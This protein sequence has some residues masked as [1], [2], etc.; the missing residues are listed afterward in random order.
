MLSSSSSP[1]VLSRSDHNYDQEHQH[2]SLGKDV[3]TDGLYT[4]NEGYEHD[5][6]EWAPR[7]ADAY[8]LADGYDE[9]QN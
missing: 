3:N 1:S 5:Y 9:N 4:I 8:A 2:S 7:E 6:D